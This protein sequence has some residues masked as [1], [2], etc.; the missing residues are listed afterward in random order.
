[1]IK[2]NENTPSSLDV[3]RSI[4]EKI[5]MY[6][7]MSADDIDTEAPIGNLDLDS[8]LAM[9]IIE[10]LQH[11]FN[12]DLPTFL[13]FKYETIRD[14]SDAVVSYINLQRNDL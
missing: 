12:V 9:T 3:E 10:E 14:C 4:I 8:I 13:F 5:S 2:K 1:M 6:C 11:E 7:M